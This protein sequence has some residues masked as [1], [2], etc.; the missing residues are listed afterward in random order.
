MTL[1]LPLSYFPE[2]TLQSTPKYRAYDSLHH[3]RDQLTIKKRH[4]SSNER[5]S[6][7]DTLTPAP[8]NQRRKFRSR[9]PLGRSYDHS[10]REPFKDPVIEPKYSYSLTSALKLIN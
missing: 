10:D 6:L 5:I 9:K 3:T 7:T 8:P 4:P 2:M 1:K